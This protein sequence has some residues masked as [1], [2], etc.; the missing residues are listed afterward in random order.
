MPTRNEIADWKRDPVTIVFLRNVQ[1]VLQS[2]RNNL[3]KID[4]TASAD[5]VAQ[6]YSNVR[7]R[8]I[9]LEAVLDVDNSLEETDDEAFDV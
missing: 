7:G 8:I 3:E 6:R 9:A 2:C 5:V 4:L 1:N